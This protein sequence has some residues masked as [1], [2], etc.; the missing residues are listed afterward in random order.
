MENVEKLKYADKCSILF[1]LIDKVDYYWN[2]SFISNGTFLFFILN[3]DMAQCD[4]LSKSLI[5][6]VYCSFM[7]FNLQAHIRG[8]HFLS[9]FTEDI[10]NGIERQH[11]DNPK[12]PIVIKK[13][14]YRW[15]I[16]YCIAIYIGMCLVILT[17]LWL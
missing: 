8:Y 1:C 14:S 11:F 4:I 16:L 5:S 9:H 6:I 2:F 10:K 12:L 3:K 15:H 17:L 7:I 13:L